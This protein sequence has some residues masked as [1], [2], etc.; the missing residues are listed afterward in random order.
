MELQLLLNKLHQSGFSIKR[1]LTPGVLNL[2]W[3]TATPPASTLQLLSMFFHHQYP[4]HQR[5]IPPSIPGI[6]HL[7]LFPSPSSFQPIL[8][9]PGNTGTG[10]RKGVAGKAGEEG[11]GHKGGASKRQAKKGE[12]LCVCSTRFES[13]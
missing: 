6:I 3:V 8:T 5:H 1:T 9:T 10:G 12:V 2:F 13:L 4:H 7:Y 11:K